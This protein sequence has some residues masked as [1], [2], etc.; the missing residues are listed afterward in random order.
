M[1][2]LVSLA[3]AYARMEQR[4]EV[5]P[6]GYSLQNI[7]YVIR[8][9]EDGSLAGPPADIRN[10]SGKRPVPKRMAVPQP[11]KRTSGI[12]SNFF[13]DKTSYVLGV[14]AGNGKRHEGEHADFVKRH[15][16]ALGGTDDT[17]LLALL[18]FL[19]SWTSEQFE[20]LGWPEE[21]KDQN[22]KNSDT[23]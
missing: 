18:R 23:G 8:L 20:A 19:L 6:F 3:G 10:L 14:T 17:G 21:M 2:M 4:G 22:V 16:E 13:W 15:N 1:T 12:A 5:P 7:S 9:K 11:T